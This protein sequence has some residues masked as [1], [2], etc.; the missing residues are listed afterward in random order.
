MPVFFILIF[1]AACLLWLFLSSVFKPLGWFG[2]RL[3]KEAKDAMTEEDN[4]EKESN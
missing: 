1:L 2:H 3:W 4:N